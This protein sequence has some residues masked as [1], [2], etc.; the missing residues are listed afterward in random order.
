MSVGAVSGLVQ[1][2]L[3]AQLVADSTATQTQLDKLTQQSASGQVADTYGGLGDAAPVS[4][5]LRPQMAQVQAWQQSVSAANGTLATTQSVLGQLESIATSFGSQALGVSMSSASGAAALA[6]QAKA[7]LQQVVTL[8]NTQTSGQYVFAGTDSTNPPIDSSAL[9]S[10]ANTASGQ[11]SALGSGAA[12]ATVLTAVVTLAGKAGFAYPG[13]SA[14]G[15]TPAAL[16]AQ[17]GDGQSV[18]MAFVAGRNSFATQAGSPTTGSYVRDLV[19]GLAGLAALTSSTA[20]NSTLQSFGAAVSQLLQGAGTAIATEQAGF[21]QV[22]SELT[23]QGTA[24]S[25][26]LTSLTTQVSGAENVD[27]AATATAL[28]QVQTQ[29][30]AS[31]QLIAG[32]KQLTLTAYL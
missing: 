26:T 25:D 10:F 18:P 23:T 16:R 14:A 20:S 1:N 4:I 24:L 3:L 32:L 28:S 11:V 13:S 9:D 15:A 27:M 6:V 2:G 22:Q 8:L 12:P 21:G 17:T 5:D 19:A 30:Q 31:F 29:L 7:A